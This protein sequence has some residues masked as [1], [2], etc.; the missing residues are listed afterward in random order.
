MYRKRDRRNRGN[1]TAN[2][3]GRKSCGNVLTK[4]KLNMETA[5]RYKQPARQWELDSA[6]INSR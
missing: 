6:D 3:N 4:I 1:A 2:G 5:V